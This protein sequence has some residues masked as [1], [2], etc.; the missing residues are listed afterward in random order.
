M[1]I[2]LRHIHHLF[3][4]RFPFFL[5][6]YSGLI[7]LLIFFIL[8][9]LLLLLTA[10]L[11]WFLTRLLIVTLFILLLLQF[12]DC[13]FFFSLLTVALYWGVAVHSQKGLSLPF[14]LLANFVT[15]PFKSDR[16]QAPIASFKHF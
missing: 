7:S 6:L 5:L 10:H 14:L 1:F 4:C 3:P 8:C 12:T 9:Q 11:L 15:Y 16:F 2:F 13:A